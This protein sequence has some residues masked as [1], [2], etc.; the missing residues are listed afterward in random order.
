[1]MPNVTDNTAR[2]RYEMPVEG[3]MAFVSYTKRGDRMLLTH[4]EVPPALSGRGI[5]TELVRQVLEDIGAKG[6]RVVPLCS[7]IVNYI[8]QHPEVAGLVAE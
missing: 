5:G 8:E 1:M 7:F 3:Q 6:L 4:T 2:H